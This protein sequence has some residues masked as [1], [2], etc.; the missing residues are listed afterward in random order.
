MSETVDRAI[1]RMASTFGRE[2][3]TPEAKAPMVRAVFERVATRYDLMNDVMSLR[4]H[5]LWKEALI[6]WLAP[7]PGVHHLDV[8]GGTGDIAFRLMSRIKAQGSAVVCDIN[9]AMLE[10]GRD[11]AIDVSADRGL[12]W[13]AGAGEAL[14]FPDRHFDSVTIAFAIRNTTYLDQV[15][16]E[17]H[18][19]SKIGGRFMCLEFT[20]KLTVPA[21]QEFYDAYSYAVIP[22]M[23]QW[24]ADDRDSY[25]YLVE[26]IRN[27]PDTETFAALIAESGFDQVRYRTLSL[28]VAAI[29]S[30]WRL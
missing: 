16:R 6:D 19:V 11:R 14:P 24:I 10:V 29:H 3:V 22:R 28:G 15:L 12:S 7:R 13:V 1:Q 20:P 21:L 5:R 8:G 30:G 27:F 9:P 2:A 25:Q 26:S 17:C 23:G 18:R 4:V